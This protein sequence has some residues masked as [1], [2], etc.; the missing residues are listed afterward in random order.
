MVPE[1][2]SK[3]PIGELVERVA[4]PVH[5]EPDEHYF[6]IGIRS[7]GKGLFDKEPV[8][9]TALGNKRVFWV[10]PDCFVVNIVFA[11]EQAVGKTTANDIGKIASHRFPMYRPKPGHCDLDFLT[12]LFRTKYGKHVLTL[13]S[14]GGAGR[15]KT[16][17]QAEFVRSEIVVPPCEEQ[18]KIAEILM[19]WDRA[20]ETVENLIANSQAQKTALIQELLIK[21]PTDSLKLNSDPKVTSL[22]DVANIII[23]NVDKKSVDSEPQIRLCNYTDVY[24]HDTIISSLPFMKS[25]AT[26][27]QV[28]KFSLKIGDVLITKDSERP[29]DIAVPTYVAETAPDLVCGYHLAIIRPDANTCGRY[30]K[31]YFENQHTRNYFASRANGATRFGLT[32]GSIA[33]APIALPTKPE[34]EK[35]ADVIHTTELQTENF[36]NTLVALKTEKAALMQQLLTGKRRVK[37]REKTA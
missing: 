9:G 14:P 32:T 36:Q 34:Q 5:V 25:T 3:V 1:G 29:D 33:N 37:L 19:T 24:A 11:W 8:S 15:N 17:G 28:K 35:I 26:S 6:Q 4:R 21:S 31:F 22:G 10:E 18:K 12:Y 16:L 7:H 13:A 23:S 27:D 2:F 20:I 30:L